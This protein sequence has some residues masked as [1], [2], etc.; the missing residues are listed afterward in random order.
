MGIAINKGLALRYATSTVADELNSCLD[1]AKY[2]RFNN[3]YNESKET[4][5][6]W[7]EALL[8]KLTVISH[9]TYPMIGYLSHV[10][11]LLKEFT[12]ERWG[13]GC[14]FARSQMAYALF[15]E[16]FVADGYM[17]EHDLADPLVDV[18]ASV[19]SGV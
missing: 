18:N 4:H 16:Y 1:F 8:K 2:D 10:G 12:E 15:M 13:Y 9:G 5:I 14:G 3:C 11:R 19:R 17:A 6:E 7:L